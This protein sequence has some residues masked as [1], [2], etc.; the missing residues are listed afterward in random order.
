MAEALQRETYLLGESYGKVMEPTLE[1]CMKIQ[2]IPALKEM[3]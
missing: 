3:S 1:H 2:R